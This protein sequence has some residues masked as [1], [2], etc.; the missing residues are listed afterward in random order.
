MLPNIPNNPNN[1]HECGRALRGR[2]DKKFCNDTC[3]N[4][5][6]NRKNAHDI[7][8][9]RNINSTLNKNRRILSD[10]AHFDKNQSVTIEQLL[11]KGF[12]FSFFTHVLKQPNG[13]HI[14]C[15]Y[16]CGYY[17]QSN[18]RV[19]IIKRKNLKKG[20]TTN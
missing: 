4:N 7:N 3:R 12:S 8:L 2:T 1:C 13:Q 5:H 15:C 20:N 9:R 6:H 17:H 18:S 14:L 11:R 16:D 10:L 19:V